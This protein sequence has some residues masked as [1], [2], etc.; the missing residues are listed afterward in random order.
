[1]KVFFDHNMSPVLARA[2]RELFKNQHEITF[3]TEKFDRRVKDVEWIS[4]LSREGRW[5]VISGDRR[6]TRNRSE[7]QAF[8]NSRLI[9]MFLSKGLSKAS[10]VKQMERILALWQNI[11]TISESVDGGA[12]FELPMTTNRVRQIKNQ[13]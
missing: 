9:G 5:V 4:V 13:S 3:L 10:V 6:I 1:V 8:R 7:Y 2:L 11:E 12:L